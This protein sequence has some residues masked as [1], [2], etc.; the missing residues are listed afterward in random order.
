MKI[1]IA[2]FLFFNTL[3]FSQPYRP[4]TQGSIGVESSYFNLNKKQHSTIELYLLAKSQFGILS[5]FANLIGI[6][7]EGH[8]YSFERYKTL[9]DECVAEDCTWQINLIH[10]ELLKNKKDR[11]QMSYTVLE[12]DWYRSEEVKYDSIRRYHRV[13]E[14][15][16]FKRQMSIRS[17]RE[18]KNINKYNW[19]Y[20][21]YYQND[22]G[23]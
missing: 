13:E 4:Y 11:T 7:K 1:F 2:S 18:V 19:R 12:P 20:I 17:I 3:C 21:L 5:E 6:D 15:E 9:Y 16:E 10:I 22:Y 8:I 23:R 14:S